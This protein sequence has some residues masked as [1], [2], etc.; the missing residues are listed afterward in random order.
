M[1]ALFAFSALA[2]FVFVP[3]MNELRII[4][5][6]QVASVSQVGAGVAPNPASALA[7]A[8][9]ERA[10]TL[11]SKEQDLAR[12]EEVLRIEREVAANERRNTLLGSVA[13]A[14]IL[15]ASVNTYNHHRDHL[16]IKKNA[17]DIPNVGTP[18]PLHIPHRPFVTDLHHPNHA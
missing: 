15:L 18:T 17:R 11:D 9:R 3:F 10:Q 6:E 1:L 5:A 13:F 7:I 12:R 8:L 16:S 2:V 4:G 14:L